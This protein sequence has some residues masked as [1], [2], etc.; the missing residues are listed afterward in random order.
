MSSAAVQLA[1]VCVPY[2]KIVIIIVL[3]YKIKPAPTLYLQSSPPVTIL[4]VAADQ[5]RQRTSPSWPCLLDQ[6]NWDREAGFGK[7]LDQINWDGEFD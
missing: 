6:I 3:K 7:G 2:L 1:T 4:P 5:S